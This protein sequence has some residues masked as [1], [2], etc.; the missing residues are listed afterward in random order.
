MDNIKCYKR[1]HISITDPGQTPRRP[2]N[3]FINYKERED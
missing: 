1:K 2:R 3:G